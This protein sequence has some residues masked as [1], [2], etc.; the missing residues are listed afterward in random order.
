MTDSTR[1]GHKSQSPG[2]G[3]PGTGT[4]SRWSSDEYGEL[5]YPRRGRGA[6]TSNES[7]IPSEGRREVL[8]Y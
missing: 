6:S 7:S 3:R 1:D 8:K 4:W 5:S 2:V